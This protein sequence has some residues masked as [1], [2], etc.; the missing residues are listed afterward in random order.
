MQESASGEKEWPPPVSHTQLICVPLTPLPVGCG[1]PYSNLYRV[2]EAIGY[3]F[4]RW[5]TVA[6]KEES[7]YNV[8]VVPEIVCFK[9]TPGLTA[10]SVPPLPPVALSVFPD[11][12]KF[13]P[14]TIAEPTLD[15]LYPI[16]FVADPDTYPGVVD[17]WSRYPVPLN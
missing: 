1:I 9:P 16:R 15:V 5:V 10:E 12:L 2:S 8:F 13:V 4:S 14:S 17:A 6:S 3:I 7:A 11:M